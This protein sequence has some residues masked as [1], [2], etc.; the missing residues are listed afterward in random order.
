MSD[1]QKVEFLYS[2]SGA[3]DSREFLARET[4]GTRV[5]LEEGITAH[6]HELPDKERL[7]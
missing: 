2:L 7:Q 4:E 6:W 3:V 1:S 5:R